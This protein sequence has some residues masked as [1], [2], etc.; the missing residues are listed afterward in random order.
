M[1]RN[2]WNF[3]HCKSDAAKSTWRLKKVPNITDRNNLK[4][5]YQILITFA[6]K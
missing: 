3:L 2:R 6:H 4:K 5:D 1:C